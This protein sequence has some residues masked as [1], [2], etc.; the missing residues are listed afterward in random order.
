MAAQGKWSWTIEM[1][2]TLIDYVKEF[3]STCKFNSIDFNSDKVRL[4]EEVR[5]AM[6][7]FTKKVTS[8]LI[9]KLWNLQN[10]LRR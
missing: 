9:R 3:K 10:L 4:Y 8:V 7:L 5:K 6:A 1:V 2:K